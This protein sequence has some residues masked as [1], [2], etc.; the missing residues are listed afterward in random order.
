MKK[1]FSMRLNIGKIVCCVV[2][3]FAGVLLM[4][5]CEGK[6]PD[7]GIRKKLDAVIVSDFKEIVSD[8]PR[9]SLADSTFF[10]ISQYTA[11]M[12]SIYSVLAVVDYFYLR[13]VQVKRTVKYRYV[14]NARQWERY[15]NEYQ[16]FDGTAKH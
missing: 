5:G 1:E 15:D 4:T 6:E 13:D 8:V 12:K 10:R 2:A 11:Y 7:A 9:T 14:K 3:L 16:Y